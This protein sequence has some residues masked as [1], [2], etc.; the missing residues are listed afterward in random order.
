MVVG[1]PDQA[2]YEFGG[3]T[4]SIF[5]QV[6]ALP[7][8]SAYPVKVSQRCASEVCRVATAL[9]ESK[10]VIASR[11]RAPKG[12]CILLVHALE[13]NSSCQDLANKVSTFV[14]SDD[15]AILARRKR[16]IALLSGEGK[17]DRFP[18]ASR[19]ARTVER[20]CGHWTRGESQQ[21]R[22][23]VSGALARLAFD[24]DDISATNL[25][26]RGITPMQWRS[27]IFR[28]LTSASESTKA[29]WRDWL[30]EL[31][32]TF[33]SGV[34][35]L[36]GTRKSF[37]PKLKQDVGD[38]LRDT[39]KPA[40]QPSAWPPTYQLMTVHQAK[41]MEFTNVVYFHPKPHAKHD[42]CPSGQW[43]GASPEE[44]RVAYVAASRAKLNFVLCVH[45][46][47]YEAMKAAQKQFVDLFSIHFLSETVKAVPLEK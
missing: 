11:E 26:T 32:E 18:G 17:N 10:S 37:G 4:T 2:I 44:K 45:Q 12:N 14:D 33:E 1:D 24:E 25:R 9:S 5:D 41:G 8:A 16:T 20:A 46:K 29:S 21:A 6:A 3:A 43:F 27:L 22:I 40:M 28:V 36:T 34:E 7:G 23:L 13:K 39:G 47:T 31:R 30:L 38:K 15:V 19:V 35:G 42:P